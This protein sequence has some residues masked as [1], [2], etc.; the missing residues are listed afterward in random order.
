MRWRAQPIAR[1]AFFREGVVQG[2]GLLHEIDLFQGN[3]FGEFDDFFNG[4]AVEEGVLFFQAVV[5]FLF[6]IEDDFAVF[7]NADDVGMGVGDAGLDRVFLAFDQRFRIEDVG[8]FAGNADRNKTRIYH[9][10]AGFYDVF[11][12]A[13]EDLEAFFRVAAQGADSC[14]DI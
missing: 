8:N 13:V 1:Q 7:F 4:Q 3:V 12:N 9:L 5:F 11:G 14:G 10:L 6:C 2:F